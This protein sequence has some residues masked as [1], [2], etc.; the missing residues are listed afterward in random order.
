MQQFIK[1]KGEKR[2][3]L[4]PGLNALSLTGTQYIDFLQSY[5]ARSAAWGLAPKSNVGMIFP[6]R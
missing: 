1:I 6:L 4:N 3:I 5:G 2:Y